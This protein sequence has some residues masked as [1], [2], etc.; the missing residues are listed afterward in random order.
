MTTLPNAISQMDPSWQQ[1]LAPEF[2][3]PYLQKLE[4]FLEEEKHSGVV[5]YPPSNL[6]FNAFSKTPFDKVSVVIIG[7]DPYHGPGQAHGLAFSVPHGVPPPP[8]L[9]NIFKELKS[10]LQ[11]ELPSHGCLNKWAEQGVFLL[12]AVLTVR[13]G[14]AA[15]HHGKGWEVF[16]DRVV[17]LLCARRRP[18][19]FLL[20]GKSALKKFHH[21]EA[22]SEGHHLALIAAHPSPLSAH[23]GFFG[24]HPFSKANDFLKA[25]GEKPIDWGSL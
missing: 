21:V 12:N 19:V 14:E 6:L 8:S 10:D 15:S 5:V 1:L 20:W 17:E 24:S 18:L 11:V 23:A 2:L 16:S 4:A 7:Q 9:K 22:C 3:K 25:K 13:D